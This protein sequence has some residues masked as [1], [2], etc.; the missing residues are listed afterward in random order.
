MLSDIKKLI[1]PDHQWEKF[2][3]R[4][5]IESVRIVKKKTTK[6]KTTIETRYYISK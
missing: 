2:P 6:E 3:R 5:L 1:D 4:G